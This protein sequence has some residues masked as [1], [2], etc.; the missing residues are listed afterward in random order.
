MRPLLAA[1]QCAKELPPPVCS[2][3][4]DHPVTRRQ[5]VRLSDVDDAI[6]M[7]FSCHGDHERRVVNVANLVSMGEA[8]AESFVAQ[9]TAPAFVETVN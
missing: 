8:G 9:A 7:Q 5:F 6:E 1:L 2:L 3:C 4:P